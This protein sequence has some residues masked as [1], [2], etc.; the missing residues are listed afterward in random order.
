MQNWSLFT[1]LS[2]KL[3]ENKDKDKSKVPTSYD[4]NSQ[5]PPFLFLDLKRYNISTPSFFHD[6]TFPTLILPGLNIIISQHA[7]YILLQDHLGLQASAFYILY[8]LACMQFQLV[9]K[10]CI[11]AAVRL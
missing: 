4:Q 8:L 10:C 5:L 11:D 3:R 1:H 7:K 9:F 2:C 6:H